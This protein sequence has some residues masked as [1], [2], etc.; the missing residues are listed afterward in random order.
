MDY[1]YKYANETKLPIMNQTVFEHYTN[2]IGKEQFRLDLADYIAKE[3][4]LFPL[5]HITLEEVRNDFFEL[6]KLDT[7]KYLKVD[8][9]VMEKYDDYKYN[10]KQYGLGV[11][12][13]PSTFN[14]ISNYFQ[15]ALRLNCSSYSFKAPIDVW[16]NGTPKDIWKCLG[17][18]WRGI[19]G[20]KKVTID[21]KEQLIGGELT[22]AS[23]MSAF[24]LGTYIATQFKPNVARTIYDMTNANTVLDTSCGWGDRLAGFYTSNAK[25]YTGCDPNPNTYANYMEQVAEYEE[26][27]GN[28]EPTIYERVDNQGRNYF[29]CMGKKYVRIYRCGAENLPWDEI[30][31]IDC[32]FTSP[33]YFS[34]EEYNKG[35]ESEEDQSWFKFNQYEKW[36]DD[37]YL[38]VSKNSFK[39]LSS[40]GHMFINIMDPK[41]KNNRYRSC[42]ELVDSLKEHF[43]GQI[44]MRIM[45]RPK[46]DKLFESEQ[47]KQEFMNKTFI[48]NVWCFAKDKNVDLFKSA[49]KGTLDSFF[50]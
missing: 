9:D 19:N 47:A 10:Y 2:T 3:R 21:G 4:P 13:A 27:L 11:I 31:D 14:N 41:V 7:S 35:G 36:R 39:S 20:M 1:L 22:E 12:D 8:I 23:Y 40:K 37:F 30:K 16:T 46:S 6:S 5:K 29:E 38:P 28:I 15:Q 43:V 48:E 18:I 32:A 49:R 33:P 34:T 50:E 17:P 45:Q 24:R 26:F 25:Q 42:D 44:G